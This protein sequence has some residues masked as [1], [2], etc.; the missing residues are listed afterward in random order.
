MEQSSAPQDE[1]Q[2]PIVEHFRVGD[3]ICDLDTEDAEWFKRFHFAE[4][5]KLFQQKFRQLQVPPPCWKRHSSSRCQTPCDK[6]LAYA[7]LRNQ[8]EEEWFEKALKRLEKQEKQAKARETQYYQSVLW[9]HAKAGTIEDLW[10]SSPPF[11]R[12][13]LRFALADF[14]REQFD[15][16]QDMLD[17]RNHPCYRLSNLDE[18]KTDD[19][20]D[21]EFDAYLRSLE[22]PKGK[23]INRLN[24]SEIHLRNLRRQRESN[25]QRKRKRATIRTGTL[26]DPAA[27]A[28]DEEI[29]RKNRERMR[30]RRHPPNSLPSP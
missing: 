16:Y 8:R 4:K 30:C 6:C 5:L 24:V 18:D 27:I 22:P 28:A 9:K 7:T 11:F 21:V 10:K 20:S 26:T 3:L 19:M 12:W 1:P 29:K 14:D 15:R 17:A 23:R 2:Y 25:E 13:K